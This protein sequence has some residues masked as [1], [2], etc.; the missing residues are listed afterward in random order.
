MNV[1][2]QTPYT[3]NFST[4]IKLDR[5]N[6]MIWKSKGISSIRGNN[7]ESL[8]NGAKLVS[9]KHPSKRKSNSHNRRK[10]RVYLIAYTRLVFAYMAPIHNN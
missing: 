9:T 4:L 3:F 6:F 8:I 7:L 5:Q 1:A 2:N 10:S